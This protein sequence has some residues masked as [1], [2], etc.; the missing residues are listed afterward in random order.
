MLQNSQESLPSCDGNV[1]GWKE[2]SKLH[3]GM[4]LANRGA[5]EVIVLSLSQLLTK[6]SCSNVQFRLC[7]AVKIA[8]QPVSVISSLSL[9]SSIFSVLFT[10]RPIA[11]SAALSSFI[12]LRWSSSTVSF[13]SRFLSNLVNAAHLFLPIR[14]LFSTVSSNLNGQSVLGWVLLLHHR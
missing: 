11:K 5:R 4:L 14:T 1:I 7:K 13:D 12:A 2:R 6:T 3:N 8:L 9:R 10:G